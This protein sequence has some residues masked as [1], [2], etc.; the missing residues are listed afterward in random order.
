MLEEI[1]PFQ[2]LRVLL[3]I[4]GPWGTIDQVRSVRLD[5]MLSEPWNKDRLQRCRER[6]AAGERPPPI[7]VVGLKFHRRLDASEEERRKTSTAYQA[8][9]TDESDKSS[10]VNKLKAELEAEKGRG[11]WSRVFGRK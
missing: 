10:E 5:S 9:L 4:H 3:L 2:F 7:E 8:L 11:L 1:P 6:L